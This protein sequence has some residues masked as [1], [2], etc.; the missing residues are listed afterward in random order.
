MLKKLN[1]KKASDTLKHQPRGLQYLTHAHS[2]ITLA[3]AAMDSRFV[4]VRT[5]QHGMAA[6]ARVIWLC[7]CVRYCRPRGWCLSVSLAFFVFHKEVRPLRSLFRERNAGQDPC[8]GLNL[9]EF[10]DLSQATT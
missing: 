5:H 4:L 9:P 10:T 1:T 6:T 7:A 2:H 8:P 3:V